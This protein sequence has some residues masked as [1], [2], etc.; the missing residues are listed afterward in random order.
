MEEFDADMRIHDRIG[1]PGKDLFAR[2]V[3]A[4]LL[5]SDG[6]YGRRDQALFSGRSLLMTR[7]VLPWSM[8]DI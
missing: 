3:L 6:A 4:A 2:L 1:Y 5:E 8:R 7:H